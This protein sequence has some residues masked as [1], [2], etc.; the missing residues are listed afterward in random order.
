MPRYYPTPVSN[1]DELNDELIRIQESIDSLFNGE[2]E[3]ISIEPENPQEGMQVFA[4]GTG[5]N[6]GSGRG[7]YEYKSSAWSKL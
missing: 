3:V 5:W 2:F 6:P 4:D 1:F 7:F